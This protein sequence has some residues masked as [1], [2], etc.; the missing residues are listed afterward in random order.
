[1][2]G[3]VQRDAEKTPFTA[4][5]VAV[6]W[7][8]FVSSIGAIGW[9]Y[10]RI[11]QAADLKA[12]FSQFRDEITLD[13]LRTRL[14]DKDKEISALDREIARIQTVSPPVPDIYYTQRDGLTR[15]RNKLAQRVTAMLRGNSS[16]ATED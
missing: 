13:R 8:L 5:S 9:A 7:L 10:P 1:M 6:F 12:E 4:Y 11:S 16:L 14:D 15:E 3:A 2:W